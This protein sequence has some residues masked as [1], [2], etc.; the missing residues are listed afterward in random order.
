METL[1]VRQWFCSGG[2]KLLQIVENLSLSLPNIPL[3]S[4]NSLDEPK[5][6]GLERLSSS[7]VSLSHP[8]KTRPRQRFEWPT[9]IKLDR[10]LFSAKKRERE[11]REMEHS[12]LSN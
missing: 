3:V 11:E 9:A 5:P 1:K 10:P 6:S 7:P 12:L 2:E 8:E 4:G